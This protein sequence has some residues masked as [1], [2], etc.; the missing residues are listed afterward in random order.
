MTKEID[1]NKARQGRRGTQVLMVLIFG[2]ILVMIVWWGVGLYGG[3]IDPE[4]P[5]GGAPTEQPAGDATVPLEEPAPMTEQ[6][7]TP[8]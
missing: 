4:D 7:A 8:Q 3:A 1:P 2:L 5:V 6:P